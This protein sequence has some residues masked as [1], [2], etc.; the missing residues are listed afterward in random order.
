MLVCIASVAF[1]A[2]TTFGQATGTPAP[3]RP[4]RQPRVI[5]P[6]G[7]T[8]TA[9]APR[10]DV[11]K[12][13]AVDSNVNVKLCVSNGAVKVNGWNRDEV[14]ILVR[15]GREFDIRVLERTKPEG[16]PSWLWVTPTAAASGMMGPMSECLSGASI[17]I[18]APVGSSF[19]ITGRSA[20]S[21]VDNI[22]KVAIKVVDGNVAVNNIPGGIN[23]STLQG[24]LLV[25]NSGGGIVLDSTNGNII[26]VDVV[27]GQ[28]GE[29]F[30][31][32]TNSGSISLK[33]VT[34]R[35]IEANSISG[36][37]VFD[38]SFSSGGIYTF[39]TSNGSI[40]M[41]IPKDSSC[42][43]VAA[44]GFGSFSSAL[45]LNFIYHNRADRARN[46][47]ATIGSGAATVNVVTTSGSI[48]INPRDPR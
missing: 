44:Y 31:A 5:V 41:N 18:D 25:E 21:A 7:A 13:M 16:P 34:H 2:D 33:N 39:R 12:A 22:K 20:H 32:K 38:G 46:L 9:P 10:G 4:I 35:Q 42:K 1:L 6:H 23:A 17:E 14:R 30:R 19:N 15:S 24:N 29:I 36:S 27:P 37:V 28:V 11:E 26:A 45:P 43:I 47:A 3:P 48:A 40:R 8:V